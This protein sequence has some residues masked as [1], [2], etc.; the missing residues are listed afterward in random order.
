M[1]QLL[2]NMVNILPVIE[3]YIQIVLAE[4]AD[5][6]REGFVLHK[7]MESI[8]FIKFRYKTIIFTWNCVS[9]K[10]FCSMFSVIATDFWSSL[11]G[12]KQNRQLFTS[13]SIWESGNS[14]ISMLAQ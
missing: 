12:R 4:D 14:S 8:N 13:S 9:S 7:L 3:K 10:N 5:H 2:Q 6:A 11:N 1:T